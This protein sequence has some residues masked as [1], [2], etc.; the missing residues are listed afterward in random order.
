[1]NF[2]ILVFS[3]L[4][5]LQGFISYNPPG[6]GVIGILINRHNGVIG[7]VFKDSPAEQG[8][9]LVN[10]KVYLVDN[11]PNN[12]DNIDGK[13]GEKVEIWIDRGGSPLYFEFI[14]IDSRLLGDD[15]PGKKYLD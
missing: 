14:R 11:K 12:C 2:L 7:K 8:G 6:R 13:V 4:I 5:V 10:D 15:F 3:F 1:M 9:L